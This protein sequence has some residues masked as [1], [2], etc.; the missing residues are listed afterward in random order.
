MFYWAGELRFVYPFCVAW[1]IFQL[2]NLKNIIIQNIPNFT[3][4]SGYFE[5]YKLIG[6]IT[7][8]L[9]KYDEGKLSF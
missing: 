2:L 6:E 9:H 7:I 1:G 4:C 5:K 8:E 3:F